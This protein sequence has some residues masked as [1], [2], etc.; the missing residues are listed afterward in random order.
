MSSYK[1]PVGYNTGYAP[2]LK[3]SIYVPP[4]R[5]T[6]PPPYIT[7]IDKPPSITFKYDR[8]KTSDSITASKSFKTPKSKR[9]FKYTPTVYSL[10]TGTTAKLS[11]KKK[12]RES[13][14]GLS[15]RPISA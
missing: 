15:L 10:A 9:L 4:T 11:K 1:V 2:P 13:L 5:K 7:K 12:R 3:P 6:P 8:F 14:S